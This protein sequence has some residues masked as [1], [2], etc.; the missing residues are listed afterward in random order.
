MMRAALV[1][2][3]LMGR[4][5]AFAHRDCRVVI[6]ADLIADRAQALAGAL[7]EAEATT[8]WRAAVA[9][10]D[11][12]L[13][14]VST[15]PAALAEVASLAIEAGKHVL[16]EKPAARNVAE[17][18]SLAGKAR[19]K[20]VRVKVGFNHRYHPAIL[21]ARQVVDSGLLGP[22]LFVR[23]RYG[24]GG[25]PGYE[26][27]WRAR[28]EA[29]GGGEL[30]DQGT[31][32]IDLA[33]YFLGDFSDVSGT[34][35][36]LFWDM[37]VEDNAFLCLRTPRGQVAWLQA[38]WTEWKNLFS[39]EIFGRGGKLQVDGLGGSYGPE[40]LTLYKMRPEM[41]PPESTVW[42]FPPPDT[43]FGLEFEDFRRAI[44]EDREPSGN[45]EDARA[46]LAIAARLYEAGR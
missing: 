41:G 17:I 36:T 11:V 28:P 6:C 25:R 21:K 32:L 20:G 37:P 9:R 44:E 42:E 46:A 8:D 31:H 45:L 24:H 29:S 1:G 19:E 40:R 38:G 14:I 5:R 4:K 34:V 22:L 7:P 43:S 35:A 23:G 18:D 13:V 10:P 16:V 3:G 15:I 12:D 27:E 26:R 33:R 2:C 30:I 39:W